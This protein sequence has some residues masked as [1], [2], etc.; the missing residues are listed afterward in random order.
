MTTPVTLLPCSSAY[1]WAR[2]INRHG[3]LMTMGSVSS[4]QLLES[5]LLAKAVSF[6][7]RR[8]HLKTWMG[9]FAHDRTL[10]L[11]RHERNLFDG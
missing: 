9:H 4:S 3:I 1:F 7:V 5:G 2:S 10:P 11:F 6:L 8:H